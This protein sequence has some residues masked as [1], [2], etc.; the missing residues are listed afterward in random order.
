M[1]RPNVL[2]VVLDALRAE[3]VSWY[4]HDRPTTPTIDDVAAESVVFDRAVSPAA[5]TLDSVASMFTGEYPVEHQSG[6]VG[7]VNA[8]RTLL[9]DRLSAA[10][11]ITGMVTCNPFLAPAFGFSADRFHPVMHAFEDGVSVRRF[12]SRTK[13]LPVHQRYLKFLRESLDR[14]FPAHVGNALQ[15]KFGLFEGDDDGAAKATDHAESFVRDQS[16]PWFLYVHYTETHMNKADELPYAVPAGD[17]FRFLDADDV[18]DLQTQGG[19]VDYTDRERDVHERLYDAAVRYLDGQVARL[20]AALEATDQWDDT[21]VVVTADHGE[22]LGEHGRIGHGSVYEPGLHVPLVVKHPDSAAT[23]RVQ[24]RVETLWLYWSLVKLAGKDPD[25]AP[26]IDLV[27]EGVP[28][29]SAV[30]DVTLAQ[31]CT[32]TWEW[33]RYD[34][35][36]DIHVIY[37]DEVKLIERRPTEELYDL[38]RDPDELTDRAA[39]DPETVTRLRNRLD[40][41]LSGMRDPPEAD[42]HVEFAADTEE[43]LRNLGYID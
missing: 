2:V 16:A 8:R 7:E 28:D 15:F 11:Y 32:G 40:E 30:P 17:R 24:E 13:D 37:E 10:G 14:N 9:T 1:T 27:G 41:R 43:R 26:E 34:G 33:S 23:G 25:D 29:S 12:F 18:P 20:R 21:L 5:T 19:E 3:N 36:G 6:R 38:R 4:G 31:D 35:S 22:L 39:D 42:A